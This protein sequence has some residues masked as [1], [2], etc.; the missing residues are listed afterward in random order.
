[1]LNFNLLGLPLKQV[2]K[3]SHLP[4]ARS[5]P[6]SFSGGL[7]T[8]AVRPSQSHSYNLKGVT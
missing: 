2:N 3:Q 5:P 1:M 6:F 8:L 4:S 7:Q